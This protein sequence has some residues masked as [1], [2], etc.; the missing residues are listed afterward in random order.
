[1]D[2][3]NPTTPSDNTAAINNETVKCGNCNQIAPGVKNRSVWA[4]V[5]VWIL[6]IPCWPVTFVY[7]LLNPKYRCSNCQSTFVGTQ[8]KN[9]QWVGPK[10]ATF[11]FIMFISILV[12]VA[13]VGILSSVVLASLSSAK[14]KGI[15]SAQKADAIV[16]SSTQALVDITVEDM[17]AS[18]KFPVEVNENLTWTSIEAKIK[19]V[20]LNYVIHD[21]DT[22]TFTD[23]KM[24]AL[25]GPSLCNSAILQEAL[26]AGGVVYAQFT[27]KDSTKTFQFYIDWA[28]CQ[29]QRE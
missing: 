14:Q 10:S 7:Y 5:I 16:S 6:F 24:E 3:I 28:D 1:M 23:E 27:V 4:Q 11:F 19:T 18:T 29:R 2:P 17:Q 12:A 21:I 15:E 9:G 25:L 26:M 20:Q 13:I 22:A 8:D